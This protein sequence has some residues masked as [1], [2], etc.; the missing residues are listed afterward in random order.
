MLGGAQGSIVAVT[1]NTLICSDKFLDF[2]T[3][4]YKV[5]LKEEDFRKILSIL[6]DHGANGF[7]GGDY[8][9][10]SFPHKFSMTYATIGDNGKRCIALVDDIVSCSDIFANG[11]II[12]DYPCKL[13][14]ITW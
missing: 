11:T 5:T 3:R 8:V 2:T 9:V 14:K 1:G 4:R 10:T 7:I 6:R 13:K 12:S